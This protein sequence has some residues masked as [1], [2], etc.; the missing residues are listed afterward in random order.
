MELIPIEGNGQKLDG[1]AMFGNVPKAMWSKWMA[2]DEE[3]R[4]SLATR[5]LLLRLDDGRKV[6]IE[7]GIGAFFEPNM[8][9][10]FGVVQSEH[11]LLKSLENVGVSHEEID[12]VILTHLHFDHAGGLLPAY[13]K[14]DGLLFP[15]ARFYTGKTQWERACHP[16]PRDRAS[17]IPRIQELLEASGRLN[18]VENETH[19]D[20]DFGISFHT[21]HG[22]TPGLIVPVIEREGETF[23]FV[24]DLV[25][26]SPWVHLPITMG[27]DRFPELVIDEK[28][29]FLARVL[30]DDIT[31]IFTHDPTM[32]MGK[33]TQSEKGRLVIS[34]T[35]LV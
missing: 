16:H 27:Y 31:L 1:G 17:F 23:A 24:S 10:R 28:K 32:V 8:R 25:P 19:P 12:V 3:N 33:V 20:L 15:N 35:E 2:P 11:V 18:L 9:E 6:L 29:S 5:G 26:A 34:E 21:V 14:G 30:D 7:T 22:H 13:G 4:I